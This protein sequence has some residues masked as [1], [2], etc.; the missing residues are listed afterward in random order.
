MGMCNATQPWNHCGLGQI[1]CH[2]VG[3]VIQSSIL[4]A[5]NV[6]NNPNLLWLGTESK[7]SKHNRNVVN[8]ISFV[9]FG[10]STLDFLD[11]YAACQ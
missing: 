4:A 6:A 8:N 1:M 10:F 11:F 3:D 9:L 7:Y 2:F 5:Y